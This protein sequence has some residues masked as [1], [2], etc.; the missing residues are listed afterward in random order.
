MKILAINWL[1]RL[2]P[3]AGG[4]EVHFFEI[5]KR[6]VERGHE[7][8]LVV[9]GWDG[10]PATETVDGLEI[11]RCGSRYS[12][13]V[14]GRAA[15][16]KVL[17]NKDFDVV[18]EDINKIPLY[19]PTL[20]DLPVYVIIPHLFG[21][22]AFTQAPFPVA[23]TVW[24]S[25]RPIP[26]V[27][28]KSAFH[29]I[30]KSTRDDIVGRGVRPDLVRVIYPGVDF[31]WLTPAPEVGRAELPTFLYTGRLQKYKGVET[32]IRGLNEAKKRLGGAK[33]QVA[34]AGDDRARLE[35][36]TRSLGIVDL[37]EFLGYVSEEK[38][39]ELMRRAWAVVF[40][41]AKE[42]WGITNIEAA[43]CGTP[44]I[45]S[46]SPGLRETAIDGKTGVLVEHGDVGAMAGAMVNFGS[47]P[48]L[49]EKLGANARTFA[50]EF[51]WKK[52]A[53][54]TEQHLLQTISN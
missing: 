50:E 19:S 44:A 28:R 15:I 31:D 5:F 11:V 25:E 33:L 37:V 2:N 46:N 48:E 18:V 17:K 8:T 12:F 32:A 26:R 16:R 41:S 4:A 34:G 49:V 23:A 42:G 1:D 24:L 7:V 20:T 53:D 22:T 45:A 47:D 14:K 21:T 3:Q 51:S 9:S 10:A 30:S 43:A 54:Q 38:K 6:L 36:V 39:R 27:Y 29:V 13:A 40:P 52:A 35:K